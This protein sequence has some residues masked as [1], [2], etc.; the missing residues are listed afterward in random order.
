MKEQLNLDEIYFRLKVGDK[1]ETVCLSDMDDKERHEVLEWFDRDALLRTIDMLCKTV[2]DIG[3]A[4]GI[5][6]E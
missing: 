4:F 5:Y 2:Y 6:E 3:K 1:Y